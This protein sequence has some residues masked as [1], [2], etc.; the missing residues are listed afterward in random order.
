[1]S[2]RINLDNMSEDFKSYIQGLD[3]QLEHIENKQFV[4]PED[5][6]GSDYEKLQT[7]LDYAISN[8]IDLCI[9]KKYE[10]DRELI[11]N[12]ES[13]V[14]YKTRVFGGGTITRNGN[15]NIFSASNKTSSDIYFEGLSFNSV[16]NSNVICFNCG[17]A[18]L[19][20]FKIDKCHFSNLDYVVYTQSY[21]QTVYITNSTF[22]KINKAVMEFGGFFDVKIS[23]IVYENSKGQFLNHL[24]IGQ[25]SG[26][27]SFSLRDSVLEGIT[28]ENDL[29]RIS[30][31][32]AF[33]INNC[34]FEANNC[35]NIVFFNAYECAGVSISNNVHL[36]TTDDKQAFI[37]WSGILHDCITSGNSISG[38][39]IND[40]TNI[41][42]G[43]VI[44][45]GD[46]CALSDKNITSN[47]TDIIKAHESNITTNINKT[48]TTNFIVSSECGNVVDETLIC[49]IITPINSG[50]NI[51]IK[52]GGLQ[53]DI[54][55]FSIDCRYQVTKY[56]NNYTISEIT[57]SSFG[58]ANQHNG[59]ICRENDGEISIYVKSLNAIQTS[60]FLTIYV[61]GQIY[62][63]YTP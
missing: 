16:G 38:I 6:V 22:I 52:G 34:Y 3:S 1:M 41:T 42:E 8:K 36:G 27:Q 37:T 61:D 47:N 11:I 18:N 30:D 57:S 44:S 51:S 28:G 26:C 25:H 63:V 5:F 7:S 32:Y 53:G 62:S 49:T 21:L 24:K 56:N 9:N 33:S 50:F 23:N 46:F 59:I 12:K 20:R 54:G 45:Q 55:M 15:G 39:K 29:I 4:T 40:T 17:D 14:R 2:G 43:R 31:P 19:I 13:D 60:Y 58:S 35:K 48:G 10:I